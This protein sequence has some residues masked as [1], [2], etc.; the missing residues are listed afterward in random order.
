MSLIRV[1]SVRKTYLSGKNIATATPALRG[2]S[3]VIETGDFLA[4]AGPSGSGK[5]SL[6]HMI[7]ALDVPTGGAVFFGERNI[8]DFTSDEL[9]LF[10]LR[11][12]G[13]IFQAYNLIGTLTAAE[14][15][16]YV[17]L[18]QGLPAQE[19]Q[20][21]VRDILRRVG[22]EGYLNRFPSEMSGG[23]QQRVAVARAIVARPKIVIADEPTANLDSR[24]AADLLDLM[25][26]LNAEKKITFLFS[27]HDRT[28]MEKAKRVVYLKDGLI[29]NA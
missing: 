14:N 11:E 28:V 27:T 15:V 20:R 8:G 10:R 6:L 3:L 1:E 17:M 7:G 21:R 5:S 24:T 23:Q 18:L 9:S 4:I 2:V 19:R 25:H 13:Y 29:G 12:V 22:L 16:E 26:S